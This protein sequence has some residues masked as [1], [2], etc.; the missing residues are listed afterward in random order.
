M[1]TAHVYSSKCS[2]PRRSARTARVRYQTA[3]R[4][5]DDGPEVATYRHDGACFTT[6]AR[7]RICQQR[8][9][10]RT[11]QQ[12]TAATPRG[13]LLLSDGL[14]VRPAAVEHNAGPV[15]R[16]ITA[17]EIIRRVRRDLARPVMLHFIS[18]SVCL[19]RTW[20]Q[21]EQQKTWTHPVLDQKLLHR[22]PK[23]RRH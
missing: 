11:L 10:Q 21:L 12:Q 22:V 7:F 16:T 6:T 1:H 2:S 13:R 23:K 20:P 19:S 18:L 4:R 3:T 8:R 15:Y 14:Y 17:P 5:H 9:L